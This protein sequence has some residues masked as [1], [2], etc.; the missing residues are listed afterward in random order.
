MLGTTTHPLSNTR[1]ETIH[2][3]WHEESHKPRSKT[4]SK[5]GGK[6]SNHEPKQDREPAK[7]R[8]EH[9]SHGTPCSDHEH[10]AGLGVVHFIWGVSVFPIRRRKTQK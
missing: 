6:G 9:H 2:N 10:I 7:V 4:F 3:P 1:K 5:C 8:R